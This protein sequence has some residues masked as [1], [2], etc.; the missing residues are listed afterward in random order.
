[1]N[2][3]M[4]LTL[5]QL[6]VFTEIAREENVSRAAARLA[7]S[8]PAASTAL[9][10]LERNYGCQL[11]DRAGKRLLINALGLELL[12]QARALLEQAVAV[13]ALLRG[14]Q[15]NGSLN[16]GATLTIGNYL[17][18]LLLGHFMQ[19]HPCCKARLHVNNTEHII[20]QVSEFSLDLGLIEGQCQH[21]DLEVTSWIHDELV[22]FCAPDHPL[23]EARQASLQQLQQEAWILREAGSGT[24]RTFENAL[25]DKGVAMRTLLELEHTE[26]IKRAVES[27]LGIGCISRLALRDAFR[28]GSLIPLETPE[29]E[30]GR[31]F[32]F[33]WHQQKFHTRAM[34]EFIQ[35]CTNLT[36][37]CSRSD[38]I[39][40][41]DVL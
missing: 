24:R 6:Q 13:D 32:S 37:G 2:P 5:R 36:A 9:N 3:N 21:P 4:R 28:R 27:G 33:I 19:R 20:S 7:M 35:L 25:K 39:R 18:A 12:P 11:F 22:V 23:A 40:L 10:E 30:L 41:P 15:G 1:M 14:Q 8:Q 16:V 26:A 31:P 38:Q 34:Q 29:L 17:A